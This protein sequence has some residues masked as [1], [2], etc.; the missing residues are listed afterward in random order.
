M[1]FRSRLTSAYILFSTIVFSQAYQSGNGRADLVYNYDPRAPRSPASSTSGVKPLRPVIP[2]EDYIRIKSATPPRRPVMPG[3]PALQVLDLSGLLRPDVP[4]RQPLALSP[5]LS[6]EG[7]QQTAYT[8]PSPGIAVGPTEVLATVHNSIA[9]Y[10]REGLQTDIVTFDQWFQDQKPA[11]CPS[12]PCFFFDP[13][14]HYDQLHG[15]FLFLVSVADDIAGTS[16]FLLSVS[17]TASYSG[18]WRTWVLDGT[19]TGSVRDTNAVLDFGQLGYDNQAVYLTGN[20]FNFVVTFRYAKVRIVKKS[21]LYNPATTALTYSDFW[22]M[23]NEDD[24]VVSSLRAIRL[25]GQP[26][27]KSRPGYMVNAYNT[28]SDKLTLWKIDNPVSTN[29]VLNRISVKGTWRY[30]IPLFATQLGTQRILDT[31]DTRI[32]HAILR[33]NVIHVAHNTG[34]ADEP[35]TFT[36]HRIDLT[37]NKITLQAR[38]VNGGHFYPAFDLPATLGPGNVLPDNLISGTNTDSNGALTYMGIK[39]VKPGEAPFDISSSARW[40][41]YFSGAVDPVHGGLW[42]YG[43][44]AKTRNTGEG[45]RWGTWA[46]YFPWA[47]TTMFTDVPSTS[48]QF[49]FINVLRLWQITSGCQATPA[50]YCAGDPIPRDQMA[51]LLIRSIIGDTFT[52][53]SQPYFTDVPSNH[54]AFR[55]IQKLREMGVTLGCTTTTFCPDGVVSRGQ[56]AMFIVRGKFMELQGDNFTAP[57]TPFFTDVA[58]QATEFRHVQKLR[59]LGLTSGCTATQYCPADPVTRGQMAIFLVRAFL[60]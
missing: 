52:T 5:S 4:S 30:D 51:V 27:D 56:M 11:V 50:K 38:M 18:G 41:D 45:G 54:W 16:H 15:R 23:K 47:T 8:P 17:N 7:I 20:M 33:N 2:I 29:P 35:V 24:S 34:Y 3:P 46:A 48:P 21:E 12:N 55:Y 6:W 19:T 1:S 10:T 44:Y 28:P 57:T 40:G 36:Y 39:G 58:S 43:E 25:R 49:D 13:A 59:E 14:I 9:R 22:N 31:G 53:A 32:P 37:S 26:G 42:T 60:N